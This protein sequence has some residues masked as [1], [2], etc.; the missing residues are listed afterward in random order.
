[1]DP[2]GRPVFPNAHYVL[3][4][5]EWEFWTSARPGLGE[6][7]VPP[8]VKDLIGN[9]ARSCLEALRLRLEPIERET[10]ICPGVRAIPAPGHTP[11]HLAI[12]VESGGE[13]LLNICD[14][15]AHPLHLA[16]LDWENGFDQAP[17]Q[18]LATRRAMAERAAAGN[19]R[20]MA[21]HFPFPSVGRIVP[22]QDG[23]W[24]WEPG[25]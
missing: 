7:S 23:G 5:L 24:N 20:L 6:L 13:S 16:Q 21:F 18:A 8:H 2:G 17:R 4:E 1:V 9:T 25:R 10:E 22:R 12:L 14:A 11:G 3:S 15:A 19:M